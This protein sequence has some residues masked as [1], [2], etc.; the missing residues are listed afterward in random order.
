MR[1]DFRAIAGIHKAW[2]SHS[3]SWNSSW[4]DMAGT[5]TPY[6]RAGPGLGAGAGG[7]R[8]ASGYSGD[9][10]GWFGRQAR[11]GVQPA[12]LAA[13]TVIL[14]RSLSPMKRMRMQRA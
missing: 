12:S 9:F 10:S 5:S 11:Q 4:N 6:P 2:M 14:S 13:A 7:V 8:A 1:H 3:C